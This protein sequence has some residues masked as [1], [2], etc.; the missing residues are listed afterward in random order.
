MGRAEFPSAVFPGYPTVSVEHPDTWSPVVI[1]TSPLALARTVA[2]GD[3]RPNVVVAFARVRGSATLPDVC[4]DVIAKLTGLPGYEEVGR[5]EERA[6][7][8]AVFRIEGSFSDPRVGTLVQAVRM[9][10]I[11]RGE[12]SDVV[13]M[14]GTCAGSQVEAVYGEI[15]AILAS[16]AAG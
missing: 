9:V 2:E 11:P 14:T 7:G 1:P 13:Q 5:S 16:A 6:E 15:R 3:F 4:A 12:V 8:F 10:L